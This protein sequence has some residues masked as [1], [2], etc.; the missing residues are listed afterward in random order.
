MITGPIGLTPWQSQQLQDGRTLES[1]KQG[2]YGFRKT[3]LR[4]NE[5]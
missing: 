4:P 1:R 2:Y 5:L 3:Q